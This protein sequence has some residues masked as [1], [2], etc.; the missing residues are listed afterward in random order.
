M[1]GDIDAAASA[2]YPPQGAMAQPIDPM[3]A[4]F[5]AK[6]FTYEE[7]KERQDFTRKAAQQQSD[8][9]MS[10]MTD[11]MKQIHLEELIATANSDMMSI[12]GMTSDQAVVAIK[13]AL[14]RKNFA[15]VETLYPGLR[16][17]VE[18][19]YVEIEARRL[20]GRKVD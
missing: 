6:Q 11:A 8:H 2:A 12:P 17:A 10:E 14:D 5:S 20:P 1:E 7:L 3:S 15:F 18:K 9:I 16:E 19:R 13:D 4:F